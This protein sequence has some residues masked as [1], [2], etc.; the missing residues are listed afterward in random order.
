MKHHLLHALF[1]QYCTICEQK[2]FEES[3][4]LL[5]HDCLINNTIADP[6][7]IFCDTFGAFLCIS[8]REKYHFKGE[9]I[10]PFRYH[11]SIKKL[12]HQLKFTQKTY[13]AP[14][15]A[16]V[17][18]HHCAEYIDTIPKD[19]VVTPMPTT[20]LRLAKRGF[21]P[22][23][24]IAKKIADFSGLTYRD[25][26]LFKRAFT[27]PQS[28]LSREER[29]ENLQNS[30]FIQGDVPK[31]ILLMDDVLT[32]GETFKQA[33]ITLNKHGAQKLSGILIAQA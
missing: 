24:L 6:K 27:I 13:I 21:N 4:D 14:L 22:I 11:K 3:Y 18:Y 30:F 32:T 9:I 15:I 17:L 7:C 10:L 23:G 12:I 16:E 19:Y 31:N 29:L 8:C 5:C 2:T 26:F 25:D 1:P 33:T 28:E 20:R